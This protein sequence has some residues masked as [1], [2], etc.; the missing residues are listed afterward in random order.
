MMCLDLAFAGAPHLLKASCSTYTNCVIFAMKNMTESRI[1]H[2]FFKPLAFENPASKGLLDD[3]ALLPKDTANLVV[4]TDAMVEHVHFLPHMTPEEIARRLLRVN[5]SDIAAMG[6]TPCYYL[7]TILTPYRE[8]AWFKAF[9]EG[10]L[11]D[12]MTYDITLLGGDTVCHS[13]PLTLSVTMFGTLPEGAGPL[14]RSGAREGDVLY[15]T[16]TIGD[17]VLG[18]A[19]E[20]DALAY[21]PSDPD[22]LRARFRLPTPR[23]Q[24]APKLQGIATCC[25]DISDGL[26]GDAE[27]LAQ[28]SHVSIDL[29]SEDIP[30]STPAREIVAQAP[31]WR[32]KLITGGDDYELLFTAPPQ[33]HAII[34]TLAEE[35]NTPIT[36]IG[37]ISKGEPGIRVSYQGKEVSLS[38]KNYDHFA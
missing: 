13:G 1:I 8:E 26:A 12:Q 3:A 23:T 11:T 24:L 33:S 10:L 32:E 38:Q 19:L 9:S 31:E 14:L 36:Q 7:L 37:T 20:N 25:M 18:L 28:A 30:L 22:A 21:M 27:K 6:A 2:D 29:I 34:T 35:T 16:G 5:L 15:V 17:A 4:S